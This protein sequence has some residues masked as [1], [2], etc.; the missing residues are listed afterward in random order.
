MHAEIPSYPCLYK[1][2]YLSEKNI[3]ITRSISKYISLIYFLIKITI[4]E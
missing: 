3:L 4:K 1:S 2:S